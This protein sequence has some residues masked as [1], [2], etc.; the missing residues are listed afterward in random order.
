MSKNRAG[1]GSHG[2]EHHLLRYLGRHRNRLNACVLETIGMG[3]TIDWLDFHFAADKSGTDA[4][5]KGLDF[6]EDK[7][8]QNDWTEFWP[9]GR[10]IQNWDAV[11]C[12]EGGLGAR[13][14]TSRGLLNL[15]G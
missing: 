9:Q 12:I 8:L 2:S 7:Y 10:G 3:E 11:G 6:L 14:R 1:S 15:I 13:G 4:E 5:W